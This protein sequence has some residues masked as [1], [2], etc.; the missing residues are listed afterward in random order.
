[1]TSSAQVVGGSLPSLEDGEDNALSFLTP[2]ENCVSLVLTF[3][4][5]TV[6]EAAQ[7]LHGMK[8]AAAQVGRKER[9]LG[10]PEAG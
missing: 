3:K 4:R 1:M 9:R 7:K 8:P 6:L 5:T 2:G 10:K